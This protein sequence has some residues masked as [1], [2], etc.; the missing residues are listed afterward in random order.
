MIIYNHS[1]PEKLITKYYSVEQLRVYP[2]CELAK[3][4]PNDLL[5]T[6]NYTIVERKDTM[7]LDLSLAV[8]YNNITD[9]ESALQFARILVI[10]G[11]RIDTKTII[12]YV[13]RINN[14]PFGGQVG[15]FVSRH[16]RYASG[17]RKIN[18][19]GGDAITSSD[20][21]DYDQNF[22][23]QLIDAAKDC[24]Y[25]PC[26]YFNYSSGM[27][28][29]DNPEYIPSIHS[30]PPGDLTQDIAP[31][32]VPVAKSIYNKILPTVQNNLLMIKQS[33]MTMGKNITSLFYTDG[34]L[35]DQDRAFKAGNSAYNT[36]G[37]SQV[38]VDG[39]S[40]PDYTTYFAFQK[41]KLAVM[42]ITANA[43][44]DC[45]RINAFFR[46]YNPYDSEQN[47]DNERG[48]YN[49]YARS[50]PGRTRES[51]GAAQP[52]VLDHNIPEG[53]VN[54]VNSDG[55]IGTITHT[56]DGFI[57]FGDVS[58]KTTI[59]GYLVE[60]G[61]TEDDSSVGSPNGDSSWD[62][63]YG[64]LVDK[65]SWLGATKIAERINRI[66]SPEKYK[67][68]L[69]VGGINIPSSSGLQENVN[70][71]R[72]SNGVPSFNTS[73]CAISVSLVDYLRKID[74]NIG[75]SIAILVERD[76]IQSTINLKWVDI[77]GGVTQIKGH[78]IDIFTPIYQPELDDNKVIGIK[79]L[80]VDTNAEVLPLPQ[81]GPPTPG[82]A[83]RPLIPLPV[84]DVINGALDPAGNP[85]DFSDINRQ[86]RQL[87]SGLPASAD[88][89][90]DP[91][92]GVF[93]PE[94]VS[95]SGGTYV[96]PNRGQQ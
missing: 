50:Y 26:N 69:S 61:S 76:G 35:R 2:V 40:R 80:G 4:V 14:G 68:T 78:R 52:S 91:I 62:S 39:K 55:S 37:A 48:Y 47:L 54:V 19:I 17:G 81:A 49:P 96:S 20:I 22:T 41:A 79:K 10:N 90:F 44:G 33:L 73:H 38:T 67:Q 95:G 88:N 43:L 63:T 36:T 29:L 64:T 8:L 51:L 15:N 89:P 58:V 23:N 30:T 5:T 59:Y 92:T 25:A 74:I 11:P 60:F 57:M 27:G 18:N 9:L 3:D 70:Y 53:P 46:Q 71:I 31:P 87:G 1:T 93:L 45:G 16:F 28:L 32:G 72:T 65:Y 84:D 77:A 56:T 7:N 13:D 24:L 85:I 94:F 34:E 66:E 86:G 42:S 75:D 82:Q 12:F 6:T 83:A 21:Y